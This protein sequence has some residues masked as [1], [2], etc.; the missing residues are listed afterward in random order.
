MERGSDTVVNEYAHVIPIIEV[1]FT[2]GTGGKDDPTREV[3]QYRTLDGELIHVDDPMAKKVVGHT[4]ATHDR[5]GLRP[6][7]SIGN[8]KI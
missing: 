5:Q 7:F 8:V 1:R 4:V 6:I 2:R 3:K